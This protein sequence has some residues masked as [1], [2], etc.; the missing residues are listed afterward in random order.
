[1]SQAEAKYQQRAGKGLVEQM[2]IE[3]QPRNF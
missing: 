2:Y 3:E 1:M